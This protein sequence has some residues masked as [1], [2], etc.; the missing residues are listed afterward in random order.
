MKIG[1]N[2]A[3]AW[4]GTVRLSLGEHFRRICTDA[5]LA[6][7]WEKQYKATRGNSRTRVLELITKITDGF[8][9]PKD[10]PPTQ[11]PVTVII[12]MD[13]P[14]GTTEE[15]EAAPAVRQLTVEAES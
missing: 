8:P 4:A 2:T 9:A 7:R 15:M 13:C 5:E 3:V 12:E 11:P 1:K 10:P 14:R 6:T